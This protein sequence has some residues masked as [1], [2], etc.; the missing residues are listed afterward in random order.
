MGVVKEDF[1]YNICKESNEVKKIGNG[2]T[3]TLIYRARER[4]RRTHT[5]N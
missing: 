1:M 2:T 3:A 5:D 4:E